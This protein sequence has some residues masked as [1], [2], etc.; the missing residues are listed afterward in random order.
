MTRD[1]STE[2]SA[3]LDQKVIRPSI[4]L[5][6]KLDTGDINVWSGIGTINF[7]SKDWLGLGEFGGITRVIEPTD[8]SEGI[9]KATLSHLSAS[10]TRDIAQEFKTGEPVGREYSLFAVFFKTNNQIDS[11][12]LLSKGFIGEVNFQDG[13]TGALIIE[14][15][16][17]ATKLQRTEFFRM[18]DQHQRFL[19]PG[20][21]GMQFVTDLDQQ[22][23]WG[24]ADTSVVVTGNTGPPGITKE[25]PFILR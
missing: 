12:I 2:A 9:I 21:L 7:L 19:F 5:E 10:Q 6:L 4:F 8:L 1:I 17:D 16:S 13:Q 23:L 11:N 20:D 14:L 22:V 25:P 24:A 15:V 18:D 3:H